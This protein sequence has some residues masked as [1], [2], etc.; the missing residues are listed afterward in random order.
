MTLRFLIIFLSLFFTFGCASTTTLPT[1]CTGKNVPP[2]AYS[3]WQKPPE[4]V[5]SARA[6]ED[7]PMIKAA[8]RFSVYLQQKDQ[9]SSGFVQFTVSK[10]GDYYIL[11]DFYPRMNV[12]DLADKNVSLTAD[13][14]GPVRGC[15]TMNKSLRFKLKANSNYALEIISRDSRK[16]N[17]LILPL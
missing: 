17:I 1:G 6:Q 3:L 13:A 2:D 5:H 16:V 14:W 12:L 7:A 10:D 8:T 15:S 9:D 11:S 4:E